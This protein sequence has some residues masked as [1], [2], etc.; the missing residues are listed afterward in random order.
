MSPSL[1]SRISPKDADVDEAPASLE[2]ENP[3]KLP[4][5]ELLEI[6]DRGEFAERFRLEGMIARGGMGDVYRGRHLSLGHAV[7]IKVLRREYWNQQ[8]L[9]AL[10]EQ[11]A[12]IGAR[13]GGAYV[14]RVLDFGRS[15][16]G[17]PF[18]VTELLDG[19]DLRALLD[20]ND[21]LP[22]D[23]TL[24]MFLAIC[25][26]V[27][28]VHEQGVVHRDVKPGNLF[29]ATEA[30]RGT[31]LK[32]LD[33]GIAKPLYENDVCAGTDF[34]AGSPVY[35]SPEQAIAPDT[36]DV[37]TDIWSLGIVLYEML[38]GRPPAFR[39]S[40]AE[41]CFGASAAFEPP[42]HL[43][44]I[45]PELDAVVMGCLAQMRELR[46]SSVAELRD[47]TASALAPVNSA[48]TY[49]EPAVANCN[50]DRADT[51]KP[52]DQKRS[53]ISTFD[54]LSR[55]VKQRPFAHNPRIGV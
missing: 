14:P 43:R 27:A 32:L 11:E 4:R 55:W 24:R 17:A 48:V 44:G 39:R 49:T 7:A 45:G 25:D 37:R 3:R 53:G 2:R 28:S 12:R 38:V 33:F 36:V 54:R 1:A 29:L 46:F 21:V 20:R 6:D 18:L 22:V 52:N 41:L 19:T 16:H 10:F 50:T 47:A 8:Q 15:E 40:Q 13:L 51:G 26:A 30:G 9:E 31:C 23:F 42:S 34:G 5:A 35:M